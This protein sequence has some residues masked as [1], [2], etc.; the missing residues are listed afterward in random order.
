MLEVCSNW[1]V[2]GIPNV[3]DSSSIGIEELLFNSDVRRLQCKN[4]VI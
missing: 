3:N 4:V 1:R 2:R